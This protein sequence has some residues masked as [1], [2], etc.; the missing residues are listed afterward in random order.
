MFCKSVNKFWNYDFSKTQ[1]NF[2]TWIF[3]NPWIY[4]IHEPFLNVIFFKSVKNLNLNFFLNW[5]QFLKTWNFLNIIII[6]KNRNKFWILDNILECERFLKNLIMGK[7][8]YFNYFFRFQNCLCF[9][10]FVLFCQKGFTLQR[11]F[12]VLKNSSCFK[13]VMF[14]KNCS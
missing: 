1:T 3:W 4:F 13:K 11:M 10:Q 8:S 14:F 2:Q 12:G 7:E 6:W 9:Q 5:E